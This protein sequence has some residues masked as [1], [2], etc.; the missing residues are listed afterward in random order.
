MQQGQQQIEASA[1]VMPPYVTASQAVLAPA[2]LA[3]FL[4]FD[5]V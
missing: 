5:C 2:E 4:V 1:Q 3:A